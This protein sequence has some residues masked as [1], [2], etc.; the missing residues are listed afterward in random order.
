M[1]KLVE[2]LHHVPVVVS[3]GSLSQEVSHITND[4]RQVRENSCFVA[5]KG[6]KEDGSSYIKQA[7]KKGAKTIISRQKP[8]QQ[9]KNITWVQV[10]DDRYAFSKLISS[11]YN[12][13]SDHFYT[14]GITGTNGKTTITTLVSA[15]L[16]RQYSTA[17]IGT[18]GMSFKDFQ[19]KTSLTTPE[20]SEIFKFLSEVHAQGCQFLVME[21]SSVGLHLFR[22][23]DIKFSQGIFTTFSGDHLDFHGTMEDY[24]QSKMLLFKKLQANDWAVINL[25][26]P[27][28]FKIIDLLNC[29]YLTYGFSKNA[30][31]RPISY[32]FTTDGIQA[33]IETPKGKLEVKSPLIG[34]INLTNIL[35]ATTSAVIKE[36]SFDNIYA[37]IAETKPIRGRLDFIYKNDFS[38]LIDYAHTDKAIE[39]LLVSLRDIVVG[40]L[41]VVF[42]AGG[43]RDKTKRPRMGEVASKYADYLIITS[44]N[45]RKEEP[46]AIIRDIVEGIEEGFDSMAQEPDRSK[47]IGKALDMA[48]KGDIVVIAGKGHEN[49]QIFKD[50]TI[51]FSDYEVVDKILKKRESHA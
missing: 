20:P 23:E 32:K 19:M 14:V 48:N 50:K 4:S 51:H 33:V 1:K 16:N 22:V 42:G 3:S 17:Q 8:D 38:V 7:I 29:K 6:F 15:I 26:D 35:A 43:D 18:L 34:K 28:A 13:I 46:N 41:I 5:I 12:K 37:A 39:S 2:L 40:R 25:D 31:I 21:V 30:D 36:I 44:D 24:F 45:P 47:A 10:K 11:F 9:Y 27:T 49:Y